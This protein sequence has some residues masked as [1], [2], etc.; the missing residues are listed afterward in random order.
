MCMMR[1]SFTQTFIDSHTELQTAAILQIDG[2]SK[3]TTRTKHSGTEIASRNGVN[4]FHIYLHDF[5]WSNSI[6][7]ILVFFCNESFM[8]FLFTNALFVT[9]FCE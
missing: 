4:F 6:D 8:V 9:V 7:A 5:K 2:N 1:F 3:V